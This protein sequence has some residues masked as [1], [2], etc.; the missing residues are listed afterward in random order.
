MHRLQTVAHI[1]QGARRD[2]RHGV[3]D[4][5]LLHLVPELAHLE[6]TAMDVGLVAASPL[7]V[8]GEP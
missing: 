8:L 5:R 2:N 1:G 3:L 6:G 7:V 4:E